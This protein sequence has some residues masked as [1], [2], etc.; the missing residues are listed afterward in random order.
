MEW[1]DDTIGRL[2]QLHVR[3]VDI[4]RRDVAEANRSLG[5]SNPENVKLEHLTPAQFK[6][7][8]DDPN[9]DAEVIDLWVRRII[10][11]NEH[12][13]PELQAAG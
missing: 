1:A 8:L 9:A 3:H 12:E 11:G 10:R 2:Y 4:L 7:V 5:S 6:A 13:F